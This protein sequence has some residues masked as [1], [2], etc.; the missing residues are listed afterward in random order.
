[1][2]HIV[3]RLM[4]KSK[5]FDEAMGLAKVPLETLVRG[6]LTVTFTYGFEQTFAGTLNLV[7]EVRQSSEHGRNG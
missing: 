1:M 2:D 6:P 4:D 5:V 3:F 7:I